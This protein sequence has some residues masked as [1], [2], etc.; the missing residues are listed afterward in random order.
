M[1]PCPPVTSSP[2]P[3]G[4][5][6]HLPSW[7]SLAATCVPAIETVEEACREYV[8]GNL[9]VEGRFKRTSMPTRSP[10]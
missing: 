9:E 6:R 8:K 3:S 7:S 1:P 5:L 10:S 2:R 4:M